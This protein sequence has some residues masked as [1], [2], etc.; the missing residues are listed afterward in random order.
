MTKQ[1]YGLSIVKSKFILLNI[2]DYHYL[3]RFEI[4]IIHIKIFKY[5]FYHKTKPAQLSRCAGFV[6]SKNG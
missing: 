3:I 1:R 2:K 5:I 4:E 6:F